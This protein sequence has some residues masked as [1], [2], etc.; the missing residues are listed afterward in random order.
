MRVVVGESRPAGT[1][2]GYPEGGS[3]APLTRCY[4]GG[5]RVKSLRQWGIAAAITKGPQFLCVEAP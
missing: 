1:A 5:D 4:A 2:I 3:G